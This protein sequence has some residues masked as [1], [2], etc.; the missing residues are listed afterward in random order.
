MDLGVHYDLQS[1]GREIDENS[2][3]ARV[4][5]VIGPVFFLALLAV[6]VAAFASRIESGSLSL[7]G[8]FGLALI[9]GLNVAVYVT[10][11]ASR[12]M[13]W[14]SK[15]AAVGVD[16]GPNGFSLLYPDGQKSKFSWSNSRLRFQLYDLTDVP[17]SRKVLS[18]AYAIDDRD[19]VSALSTGAFNAILDAARVRAIVTKAPIRRNLLNPWLY[20]PCTWAVRGRAS[21]RVTQ[22]SNNPAVP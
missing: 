18:T 17:E 21:D 4:S 16:V 1:F 2:R 15:R 10:I 6:F 13:L 9:G 11:P 19:R 8:W 22:P 7:L 20:I 5:T 3:P 14:A 12:H